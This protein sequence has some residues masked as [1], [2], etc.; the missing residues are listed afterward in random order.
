MHI[1]ENRTDKLLPE[2]RDREQ[3]TFS[4]AQF[5]QPERHHQ[6]HPPIRDKLAVP[7][8]ATL[9]NKKEVPFAVLSAVLSNRSGTRYAETNSA[10]AQE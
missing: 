3:V 10:C 7:K 4:G 9:Q 2:L 1:R 8:P 5:E 6:P